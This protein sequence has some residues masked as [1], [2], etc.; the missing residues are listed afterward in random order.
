MNEPLPPELSQRWGHLQYIRQRRANEWSSTCPKCGDTGHAG[1]EPPDR[2]RMFSDGKPRGWCRRCGYQDFAD[3]DKKVVITPEER[4]AWIAERVKRE[5][6]TIASAQHAIELLRSEATWLR[7]HENM[8][9]AGRAF[10][11]SKGVPDWAQKYFQLGWCYD[12]TIWSHGEE[13]HTP[14]ATIPV[15]GV[16]WELVNLRHRLINPTDP[17]DKYRPDRSGIPAA[18]YLTDPDKKPQGQCILIEGEIKSIVTACHL[19]DPAYS[20]I[21][22]PGK[23][24]N[25]DRLKLLDECDRIWIVFDPDATAQAVEVARALGTKRA[26]VVRLPVKPDDAFTMYGASKS[27]FVAALHSGR[28]VI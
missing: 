1:H 9:S 18:L 27:D 11:E 6:E 21:G 10:W 8:G 2:F 7:Y 4:Q 3:S 14:T 19:D 28:V 12:K 22:T 23:N 17:T 16:G 24:P 5:R 20:I 13:Y 15:F 25:T 26:R